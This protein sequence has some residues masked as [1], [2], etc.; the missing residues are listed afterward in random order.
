MIQFHPPFKHL[1]A[2]SRVVQKQI[3]FKSGVL[4]GT[5][6]CFCI[7][8]LLPLIITLHMCVTS[9]ENEAKVQT[10]S[11]LEIEKTKSLVKSKQILKA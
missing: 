11:A 6:A 3:S 8:I 7:K 1:H 4:Q 5:L 2:N 10:P 9:C